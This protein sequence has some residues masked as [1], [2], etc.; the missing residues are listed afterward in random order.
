MAVLAE[1][2]LRLLLTT[3]TTTA[4]A[5]AAA[6]TAAAAAAAATTAATCGHA[7]VAAC[8]GRGLLAKKIGY[9][10]TGCLWKSLVRM[11]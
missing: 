8:F 6:A 4:A 3:I 11:P 2:L 9:V 5:A 1:L 10:L 7:P